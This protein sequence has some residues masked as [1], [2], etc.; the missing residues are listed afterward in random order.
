ME[1][2]IL[3]NRTRL[4]KGSIIEVSEE[5]ARQLIDSGLA[6]EVKTKKKKPKTEGKNDVEQRTNPSD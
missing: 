4:I 6:E 2:K 5:K 3:L 1:V